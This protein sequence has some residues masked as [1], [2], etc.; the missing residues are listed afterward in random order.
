MK[1]DTSRRGATGSVDVTVP[2]DT[3]RFA[4]AEPTSIPLR[5]RILFLAAPY[6]VLAAALSMIEIGV[7]V[8]RP[9]VD[10]LEWLVAA[11]QQQAQLQD[12]RDVRIYE[13]DPLLFWRLR[14]GLDGVIWDLTP[15]STNA[16]GLRY[17]RP[18]EP[19]K[20]GAF[21]I[22]C[23][24]DSVT[25]GYRVPRVLPRRPDEY[26]PA[27]RPYPALIEA[28]LRA[29]NPGR[30]I[31]VIPLAVPG[32]SSHQGR[33]WL[34]RDVGRLQPDIVTACFGWNDIGRR[35]VSDHEAMST[36]AAAVAARRA[37]MSSQ[38]LVHLGVWLR[39]RPGGAGGGGRASTMRVP[40]DEYVSNLLAL[41]GAA[42][43]QGA[44]PVLI[45]P[46]Y[47]DRVSHPPEGDDIAAHRTALREA[48]ARETIAYLEIPE[49]T[50][51]AAPGNAPLFE[52]HI[53]PNHKGHK[54]MAERLLAFL[55][56]R[57]LLGDLKAAP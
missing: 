9:H 48:A 29:A 2:D 17:P 30:T 45:G 14:P 33:A 56:D 57:H 7:R 16:Q 34:T 35:A 40:R 3:S 49:L 1:I 47:R 6:A 15:V 8:T 27:W 52:E 53:H 22:V 20:P 26:D 21:R 46:V 43:A 13:G 36:N 23:V 31:D 5:R 18:V 50:E 51:D 38:A 12:H 41:A 25:F 39:G 37:F 19:K 55:A 42:R 24:G 10:P 54:L 32:Y 44:K 4:M 28:A 11:P